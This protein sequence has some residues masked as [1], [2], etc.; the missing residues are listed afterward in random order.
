MKYLLK[1][2]DNW[3]INHNIHLLTSLTLFSDGSGYIISE[4][5]ESVLFRF[6]KLKQLTDYLK[7][8]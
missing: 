5:G 4:D 8:N 2:F 7:N 1:L 6:D 3:I